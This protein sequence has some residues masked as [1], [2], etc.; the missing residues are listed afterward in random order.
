[1]KINFQSVNFNADSRLIEFAIKKSNKIEHF[2]DK[3]LDIFVLTKVENSSNR[4]NKFAELIIGIPGKNVVVKKRAK[5]FEEAI[6]DAV[7]CAE[8]ILKKKKQKINS[9]G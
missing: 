4:I 2:Y 9:Y 3:V 5:T 1:M 7:N 8:R 6:D